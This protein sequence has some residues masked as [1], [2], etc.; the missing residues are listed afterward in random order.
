MKDAKGDRCCA[1]TAEGGDINF[2]AL[3]PR[4]MDPALDIPRIDWAYR[5]VEIRSHTLP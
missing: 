1:H 3:F 5:V 4:K 2:K